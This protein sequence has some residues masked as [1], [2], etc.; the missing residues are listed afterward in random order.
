MKTR[1][2]SKDICSDVLTDE[3]RFRD[4]FSLVRLRKTWKQ[5]RKELKGLDL[6]D[7]IDCLDWAAQIE[8]TL[9]KIREEVICG[10]LVQDGSHAV[11]DIDQLLPFILSTG[12]KYPFYDVAG[13]SRH[14]AQYN[15]GSFGFKKKIDIVEVDTDYC[16]E[17]VVKITKLAETPNSQFSST[18]FSLFSGVKIYK[19]DHVVWKKGSQQDITVVAAKG[20]EK[21]TY[22]REM[23]K[24]LCGLMANEVVKKIEI[25]D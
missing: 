24:A 19:K 1:T 9:P 18:I 23:S 21:P 7:A 3:Q 6:R 8:N 22:E 5:V 10:R 4:L 20:Y 12:C 16:V 13:L 2:P 25:G 14:V 17:P 15:D 11:Q